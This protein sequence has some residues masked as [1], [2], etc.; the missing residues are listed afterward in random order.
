MA[1]GLASRALRV[2]GRDTTRSGPRFASNCRSPL[3]LGNHAGVADGPVRI[4]ERR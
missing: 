1:L 3:A 2:Y 4:D